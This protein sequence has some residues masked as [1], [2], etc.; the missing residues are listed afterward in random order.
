MNCECFVSLEVWDRNISSETRFFRGFC[1]ETIAMEFILVRLFARGNE[2][3]FYDQ[4]IFE[5]SCNILDRLILF[6]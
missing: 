1:C 2:L 3:T 6:L 4:V 5:T